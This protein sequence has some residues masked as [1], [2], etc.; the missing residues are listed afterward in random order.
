MTQVAGNQNWENG[1]GNSFASIF[2]SCASLSLEDNTLVLRSVF[3]SLIYYLF[4]GYSNLVS[5]HLD[6]LLVISIYLSWK[7][8]LWKLFLMF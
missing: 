6:S 5:L 8:V 3:V 4:I 2:A 7:T 1:S